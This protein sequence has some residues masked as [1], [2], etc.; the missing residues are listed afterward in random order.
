MSE[1]KSARLESQCFVIMTTNRAGVFLNTITRRD[2]NNSFATYAILN[3]DKKSKALDMSD[4]GKRGLTSLRMSCL[5]CASFMS[6]V[7]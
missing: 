6:G 3:Y 7:S 4:C 1:V 2:K 5:S